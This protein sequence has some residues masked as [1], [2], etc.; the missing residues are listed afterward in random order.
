MVYIAHNNYSTKASFSHPLQ[1][2]CVIESKHVFS[3][4]SKKNCST[5]RLIISCSYYLTLP[6]VGAKPPK[7][8]FEGFFLLVFG[9]TYAKDVLEPF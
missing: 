6:L 5:K 4:I 2:M 9:P 8:Y 3:K 7:I 1:P